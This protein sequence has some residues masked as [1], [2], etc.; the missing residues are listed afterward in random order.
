MYNQSIKCFQKSVYITDEKV[1]DT[2]F[3]YE[4]HC[5]LEEDF[6]ELLMKY[7]FLLDKNILFEARETYIYFLRKLFL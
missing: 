1:T 5:K 3:M 7:G 6:E 4:I 2:S